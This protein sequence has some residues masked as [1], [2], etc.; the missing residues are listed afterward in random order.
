MLITSM[1]EKNPEDRMTVREA[2]NHPWIHGDEVEGVFV[3]PLGDVPSQH[4][5]PV[6]PLN[7]ASSLSKLAVQYH[8]H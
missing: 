6:V 5:D 4:G 2:Q 1:T 8:M 3:P 7:C